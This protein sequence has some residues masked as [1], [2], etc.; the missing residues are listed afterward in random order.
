MPHKNTRRNETAPARLIIMPPRNARVAGLAKLWVTVAR[1]DPDAGPAT[2]SM[3]R[4]LPELPG[5]PQS[6]PIGSGH[7]QARCH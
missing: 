5:D 2:R 4:M 3:P 6:P 7:A 1:L